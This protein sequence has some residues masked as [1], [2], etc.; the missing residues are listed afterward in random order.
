MK[1]KVNSVS[2]AVVVLLAATM[3]LATSAAAKPGKKDK[4]KGSYLKPTVT[5]EQAMSA[6]KA[7]LPKLTVGKSFVKTGKRGEKKLEVTLVLDGKIVSRVRLNP[8]TG[9][10]L[11]KGQETL[12]YEVSASQE[13]AVKI[14]QQAIPNLEVASVSL[15]KQG[16]WKVDLTLK[17]AVI[18]SMG[19]HGGDGSILPDWK[20][21]RDATLY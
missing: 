12:V 10:I 18:A 3:L 13:Q 11:S 5:A 6:V 9:E 8:A 4:E 16:E 14:V 7:A 21:S 17:K 19:V 1:N 15:G 20:A 2:L